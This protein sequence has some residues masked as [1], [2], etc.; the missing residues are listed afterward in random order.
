MANDK[1]S[2]LGNWRLAA[3]DNNAVT[4]L[5]GLS[6]FSTDIRYAR[7]VQLAMGKAGFPDEVKINETDSSG[8]G[9]AVELAKNSEVVIMV[10]GEHGLQSGEGR[11]RSRIDLPG[12]QQQLLEAVYNVN[13]KIVLVLMNGRPLA[14]TWANQNIP[15][16]VE[17]WQPGM[18]SGDAIA[19]VLFGEYNPSGKLP[20]TFPRT[21]GQV[22]IYYNHYSTGRPG[23]KKEVFWSHY[24]DETNEPLYPFGYGLSYTKFEYSDLKI[25]DANSLEIKVTITLKNT[26][27]VAG[28]EVA[29]LY[30][31]DKVASIVRPVK[32][33]KGFKKLKL[34]AGEV[35][36]IEFILTRAE[37]GFYTSTGE[38]VVEPGEFDIMVGT[39]SQEGVSGKFTI[40]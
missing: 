25:D 4:V 7:G 26:G 17:A 40:K 31:R 34:D 9:E 19:Q 27:K 3:D 35:A 18:Q 13:K 32:E 15:A 1:S 20:M 29:Q 8:I 22:P 30:I 6:K 5:E 38:F 37:L 16:I 14:I 39:N 21:V 2:P 24:T 11:S 10:L 28:E 12:L 23:P 33:L 36:N